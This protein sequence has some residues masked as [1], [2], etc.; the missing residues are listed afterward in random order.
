MNTDELDNSDRSLRRT[1]I[2]RIIA[3]Y[4]NV[5]NEQRDDILHYIQREGSALDR[6]TIASNNDISFQYRQLCKEH[7][8]DRLKPVETAIAIT[9]G[10]V[11]IGGVA[12]LSLLF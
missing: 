10:V 8:I 11:L 7:Y 5:S 12:L 3:K 2:E 9:S 1:A 4:P 6:A